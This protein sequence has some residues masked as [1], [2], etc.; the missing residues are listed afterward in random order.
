MKILNTLFFSLFFFISILH[1]QT[2]NSSLKFNFLASESPFLTLESYG[3]VGQLERQILDRLYISIEMGQ[4][5][6]ENKISAN[7]ISLGGRNEFD[8]AEKERG[9]FIDLNFSYN[10]LKT[11]RNYQFRVGT[12][13]G[14]Y[15]NSMSY[16]QLVVTSNNTITE[17]FRYEEKLNLFLM[18]I[19]LEYYYY[20]N[21]RL[22]FNS[23][24][25]IKSPPWPVDNYSQILTAGSGS[26]SFRTGFTFTAAVF[27]SVGF[28]YRL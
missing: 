13:G 8:L 3:Y 14:F 10:L 11:K 21:P 27:F 1:G 23:R 7:H 26:F 5:N 16:P 18:N 4:V 17:V 24:F 2:S 15:V 6:G 12:G 28:S 19:F 9:H 20:L 22:A 25:L